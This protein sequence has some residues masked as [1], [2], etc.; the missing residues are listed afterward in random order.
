MRAT[1]PDV[2]RDINRLGGSGL[3]RRT[4]RRP[5]SR[6]QR[7]RGRRPGARTSV[8]GTPIYRPPSYP[9]RRIERRTGRRRGPQAL[10]SGSKGA[11]HEGG[12]HN[13]R[14]RALAEE[15]GI[16]VTR[17]PRNRCP[18]QRCG[19][20]AG[21]KQRLPQR[22]YGSPFVPWLAVVEA[23]EGGQGRRAKRAL[24]G[25]SRAA[26][27]RLVAQGRAAATPGGGVPTAV[28]STSVVDFRVGCD[29]REKTVVS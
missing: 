22:Q 2:N 9:G 29:S 19:M 16:E 11:G 21:I 17:D 13:A 3:A 5:L 20:T 4:R 15:L 14:F 27:R 1:R 24:T 28:V 18:L 12:G 6:V 23:S 7:P 26:L 10:A 8:V 25:V